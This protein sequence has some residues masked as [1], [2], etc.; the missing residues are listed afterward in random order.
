ML[1]IEPPG[2]DTIRHFPST[3]EGGSR[4]FLGLNRG[5]RSLSIDLK[6]KRGREIVLRM[7]KSADVFIEGNRP[8]VA[9]ELGLGI[10]LHRA[11]KGQ[12]TRLVFPFVG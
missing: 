8:G 6:K 10:E 4:L 2:G 7:S 11:G 12:I 9:D 3:L 1:K 5:K